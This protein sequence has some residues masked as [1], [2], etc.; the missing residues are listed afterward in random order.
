VALRFKSLT[1]NLTYVVLNNTEVFLQ[2]KHYQT[3][4]S[5]QLFLLGFCPLSS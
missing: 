4:S 5:L 3:L 2:D 1:E